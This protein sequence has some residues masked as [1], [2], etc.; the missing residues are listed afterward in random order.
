M[1]IPDRDFV[2]VVSHL[3]SNAFIGRDGRVGPTKTF[4]S[5]MF[6]QPCSLRC[7]TRVVKSVISALHEHGNDGQRCNV[8][9]TSFDT[10]RCP[11]GSRAVVE[12][13]RCHERLVIMFYY[14][15]PYVLSALHAKVKSVSGLFE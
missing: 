11:Q 6:M 12:G 10:R 1:V 2:P 7:Y 9:R 3:D 5:G 8:F 15:R 14:G 4:R 13:F